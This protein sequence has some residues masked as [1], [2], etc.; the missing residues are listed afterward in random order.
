MNECTAQLADT[1]ELVRVWYCMTD[2]TYATY[3][4]SCVGLPLCQ[5]SVA[6][7]FAQVHRKFVIVCFSVHIEHLGSHSND[8]HEI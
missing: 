3:S 1:M 2:V 6:R 8:V 4:V 5:H 7:M